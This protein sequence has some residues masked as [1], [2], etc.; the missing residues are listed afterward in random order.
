[1]RTH[2]LIARAATLAAAALLSACATT[3]S[4]G[5][6]GF[7]VTSVGSGKG[8]DLGGLAGADAHCQRLATAAGAG[9]RKWAA[10]LSASATATPVAP[11]IHARDRIGKGPWYNAKGVLVAA[12]VDQLHGANNI[13]KTTALTEAGASVNGRGDTPNMHDVLTGSR[14]DGTALSPAP[15]LTCG[16]WTAGGEGSAMLG[17]HDRTGLTTDPWALSWNAS[18]QS[19][20]CGMDAL[21][22]TGG[23]GLFYCF[24]TD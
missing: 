5:P 10:Y 7:F 9:K 23:A 24:A 21:K 15:N 20:G 4:T 3:P 1:M 17:H 16:N 6:M 19:R 18:H 22:A 14:P 2:P 12:S 13:T 11:A 8:G